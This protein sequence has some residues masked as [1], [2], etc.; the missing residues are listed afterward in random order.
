MLNSLTPA[1]RQA[2]DRKPLAPTPVGVVSVLGA[3]TAGAPSAGGSATAGTKSFKVTAVSPAGETLLGS[4]SNVV[5]FTA[6]NGTS[7]LTGIPLGVAGTTARRVYADKVNDNTAGY[8]L[9]LEITDNTTT[10]GTFNIA[11]A[12][13][14][15]LFPAQDWQSNDDPYNDSALTNAGEVTLAYP[16]GG[17]EASVQIYA[18]AAVTG[19]A[20]VEVA[21]TPTGPWSLFVDSANPVTNPSVAGTNIR[22]PRGAANFVRVSA[23]A[24]AAGGPARANLSRYHR[25]N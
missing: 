25:A 1:A 22:I 5:T 14:Q 13:L 16:I 9:C 20:R 8:F 18:D 3:L 19:S 17:F 10:I 11:D 12:A 4:K 23:P 15:I 2:Q 21:S 24:V 7:A 6:A